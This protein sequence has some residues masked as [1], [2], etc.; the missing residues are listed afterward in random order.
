MSRF[1]YTRQDTLLRGLVLPG[2]VG[3]INWMLLGNAYWRE[4][5]VFLPTT[6]LGF[7]VFYGQWLANNHT[8]IGLHRRYPQYQQTLRR[9]L[10]SL[11]LLIPRCALTVL[12]V[13]WFYDWAEWGGYDPLPPGLK[14]AEVTTLIVVVGVTSAFESIT[15]FEQWQ[16]LLTETEKLK[17]ANLQS[18][19]E[20]LQQ[21][22][23]PHFLFN[24]LNSLSSLIEEDPRQAEL[25][26]DELSS[27]YRYLLRSNESEL[28]PLADELAFVNSYF[29]LLGIRYGAGIRFEQAVSETYLAYQ[30]P[31]LT[32]QLLV[33]NAVK[34]NRILPEEPLTIELKTTDE[35][36]LL[37]RNSLQRR[38]QRALSNQVGLANILNKYALLRQPAPVIADNGHTF[39]VQLPLIHPQFSPGG[40]L[41]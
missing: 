36:Q 29:Y 41:V 24:S 10:V 20:S 35:G 17:K 28:T 18:Q 15:A 4:W 33:E 37:V 38:E 26:L 8:A 27:V 7:L 13:Y 14:W 21:Q 6:L 40:V 5:R 23:N 11:A 34:H 32:L 31:P 12:L 3:V 30:I 1:T 39:C 22:V 19:F 25:F 16:R 2:Y 9:L